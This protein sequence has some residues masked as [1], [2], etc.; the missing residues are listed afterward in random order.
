MK[1]AWLSGLLMAG[2]ISAFTAF[3]SA[4]KPVKDAAACGAAVEV[5][6]AVVQTPDGDLLVTDEAMVSECVDTKTGDAELDVY[7]SEEV[8]DK[9]GKIL[10]RAE[11]TVV[12]EEEPVSAE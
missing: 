5:E 3:V 8:S 7:K 1:N 2:L 10:E 6:E 11:E 9:D 4:E 12:I